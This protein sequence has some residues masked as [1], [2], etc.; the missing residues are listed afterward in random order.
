ME[1]LC[2]RHSLLG[3]P[4]NSAVFRFPLATASGQK[5]VKVNFSPVMLEIRKKCSDGS[6]PSLACLH[7]NGFVRT[8]TTVEH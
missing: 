8:R 3:S 2:N 1:N 6:Q 5:N 4:D 7:D